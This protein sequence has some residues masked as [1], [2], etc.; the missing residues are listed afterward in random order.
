MVHFAE[1]QARSGGTGGLPDLVP[2]L[3]TSSPLI[4]L[5][6]AADY[7]RQRGTAA[8]GVSR[9][10]GRGCTQL[11]NPILSRAELIDVEDVAV[12]ADAPLLHRVK[13]TRRS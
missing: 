2:F 5:A 3:G 4:G 12:P 13:I 6:Y 11:K 7:L 1:D 10:I 8:L 9:S